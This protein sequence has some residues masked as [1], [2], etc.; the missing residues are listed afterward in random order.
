[1]TPGRER[2]PRRAATHVVLLRGI[3]V[4]GR[5]RLPMS[6][7]GALLEEAGCSDVRTS[8]QSVTAAFRAPARTAARLPRELTERL[9]AQH[10]LEIPV[11][12]RTAAELERVARANPFLARGVDPARL[13]VAFLAARPT[14]TAVA[15]LDPGRSP[16]D[17]LAVD[18]GEIYL[19]LPNGVARTRITN[20]WLDARLATTS[21]VRNWRTVQELVALTHA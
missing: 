9:A 4:G 3:N 8:V 21:T 1:M 10:G 7:R 6:A 17:E 18:G 14:P 2:S 13:H 15:S 12:L 5:N 11:V 20:A 19:H 16:P